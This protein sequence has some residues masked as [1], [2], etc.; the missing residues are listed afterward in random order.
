MCL[1]LL[2][3]SLQ[4]D[5]EMDDEDFFSGLVVVHELRSGAFSFFYNRKTS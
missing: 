2:R 3:S 5:G 4:L 1:M